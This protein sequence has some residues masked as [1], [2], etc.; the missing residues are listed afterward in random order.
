MKRL[1]IFGFSAML[2][3]S[4]LTVQAQQDYEDYTFD[5]VAVKER[6][7]IPYPNL[8]EADVAFSKRIERIIDVR[9]KPNK[10]MAWP[11]NPFAKM[12]YNAVMSEANPL[13]AYR[14]DSL[15]SFYTAE[16]VQELGVIKEEQQIV[17][18]NNPDDIYD[19]ID[20][21]IITPFD[22]EKIVKW[23]IMEDWIFDKKHGLF[24][25][26]IIAVAPLYKPNVGGVELP[27][28]PLFW[29]KYADLRNYMVNW[30]VFNTRNDAGR[31]S[32]DHFFEKRMFYSY[33]IKEANM[34]DNMI[35]DFEEFKDNGLAA[36]LEAE[37]IKNDLFIMEHDLWEY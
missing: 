28:Q 24:F 2:L 18:P 35:R 23:R 20:T 4:V 26:R 11:R 31:T 21:T 8:R 32:Y 33:I 29:V 17:N 10:I 14:T 30:E 9:Q 16:E 15:L 36:L 12:V 37:R 22:P 19:L 1:I 6:K 34:Y 3:A 7:A 5:K 27:E 25:A 13:T